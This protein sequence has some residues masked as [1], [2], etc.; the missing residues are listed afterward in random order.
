MGK[1]GNRVGLALP[2]PTERS[3][4]LREQNERSLRLL[5]RQEEAENKMYKIF[6]TVSVNTE[7][8]SHGINI[9]LLMLLV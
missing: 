3:R 4:S 8:S 5:H 2:D 9:L 7:L 6:T 1:A